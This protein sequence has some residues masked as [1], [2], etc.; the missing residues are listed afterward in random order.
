MKITG[1]GLYRLRGGGTGVVDGNESSSRW[2]WFGCADGIRV[3]WRDDGRF[4]GGDLDHALDIVSGPLP[5]DPPLAPAPIELDPLTER[6][7][8]ALITKL[9]L[10]V[11]DSWDRYAISIAS[12]SRAIAAAL[13]KP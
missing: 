5:I 13:R 9:D 11:A 1:P 7:A 6:I 10:E 12:G 3:T 8:F 2:S 4:N